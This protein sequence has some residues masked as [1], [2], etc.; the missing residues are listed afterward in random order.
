MATHSVVEAAG[1]AAATY[2]CQAWLGGADGEADTHGFC[3]AP[4]AGL[5]RVTTASERAARQLQW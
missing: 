3:V 4:L 2:Q 1:V 5:G